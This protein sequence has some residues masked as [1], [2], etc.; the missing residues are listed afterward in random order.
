MLHPV[1][2]LSTPCTASMA[3]LLLRSWSCKS[4]SHRY[5]IYRCSSYG[6]KFG[7]GHDIY[8]SNN[9]ASNGNSYTYCDDTYPLPPGHS[10]QGSSCRFYAG[11]Y[12]FTPDRLSL[13]YRLRLVQ[14]RKWSPDRKWSPNWTANDPEPQMIPDVNRKWSRRK[15]AN[16]MDFGF[17]DFFFFWIGDVYFLLV[18]RWLLD[19]S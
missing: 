4:G 16:G 2:H 19:Y 13:F 5:A 15:T 9:A 18:W 17:L 11:S 10:L 14:R 12:K 3:S 1:N 6:P 8:I 7:D